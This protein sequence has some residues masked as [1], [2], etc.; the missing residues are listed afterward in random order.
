MIGFGDSITFSSEHANGG[1]SSRVIRVLL[2]D[3]HQPILDRVAELLSVGYT[4]V[5]AVTRGDDAVTEVA[6]LRPDI[7]VLDISMPGL[8]GF[9]VAAQVREA[10]SAAAIVF[11]SIHREPEFL[12][13]AWE[14]GRHGLRA[15]VLPRF[16]PGARH[17]RGAR[18]AALRIRV[19]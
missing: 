9:E 8:N 18:R 15:E 13:A 1:S 10:G 6:R 5:A 4:V 17:P 12:H 14:A 2:A 16:G 7:L 3:D 19:D 11:L